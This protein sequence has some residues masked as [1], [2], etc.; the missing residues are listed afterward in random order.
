MLIFHRIT[1]SFSFVT[2]SPTI[3]IFKLSI[4]EG[5]HN[6]YFFSFFRSFWFWYYCYCLCCCS[7][8]AGQFWGGITESPPAV[9][10]SAQSAQD[11]IWTSHMQ[12]ICTAL[13]SSLSCIPDL[14]LLFYRTCH[15]LSDSLNF[16]Y[17][18]KSF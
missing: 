10:N 9:L 7:Y 13:Y 5:N 12:G 17:L 8:N 11:Q 4:F 3:D 2:L 1:F 14:L 6:F 15:L 16:M 18:G